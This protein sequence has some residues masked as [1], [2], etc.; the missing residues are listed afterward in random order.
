MGPK[1]GF[2]VLDKLKHMNDLSEVITGN[3]EVEDDGT[4]FLTFRSAKSLYLTLCNT[5]FNYFLIVCFFFKDGAYK[6]WF[7]LEED[8]KEFASYINELIK[9]ACLSEAGNKVLNVEESNQVCF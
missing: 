1:Y 8:R 4:P 9:T 3:L 2:C 7:F 5:H 6:M